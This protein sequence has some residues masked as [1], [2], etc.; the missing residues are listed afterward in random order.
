MSRRRQ[1]SI[2]QDIFDLLKIMPIWVGPILAIVAFSLFR[3][4]LPSVGNHKGLGYDSNELL[5][6][7]FQMFS[8]IICA[9]ILMAWFMAEI[10]KLMNRRL[11]DA[12]T[13]LASI[14]DI[15]W[16]DFERLVS[17]AY[18]RK[19]YLAEVVGTDCGDGGVDIRLTGNGE[20][21]LVQ[22][23]QWKAYKVGVPT[24]RELLGVVVSERANRGI[25]VTS[26]RFT[27]DAESFAVQNPRIELVDGV[28]LAE[29]VSGVQVIPSTAPQP[30]KRTPTTPSCP[31]CNNLMVLRTGRK[32]QNAGSQFW[33]C[34]TFPR[35]RG[36]RQIEHP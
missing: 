1:Q 3:F 35:C 34:S 20:K 17:E 33:G 29:L 5:R 18:G 15:S 16:R 27:R 14:K 24:V 13:G 32:G 30:S 25:V 28:A 23:K 6:P 19:G 7:L 22:C 4:V 11:L 9:A 10:W 2:V 26:G 8:W 36:T 31:Q 12:Q 21:V